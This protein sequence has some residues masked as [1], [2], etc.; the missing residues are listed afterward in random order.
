MNLYELFIG[1]RYLKSK[2]HQ[3][4]ISFN[5][6]LSVGIVFLGVFILVLV[7]SVMNGFQAQIK[8]KILDIDSHITIN[9]YDGINF[10]AGIDDYEKVA[11]KILANPDVVSAEP[12]FQEEGILSF[13]RKISGV[14]IRGI[15]SEEGIPENIGKFI[16]E[17]QMGMENPQR[18]FTGP[19]QV[20][21][22]KELSSL[23]QIYIDDTIE[24]IVAKQNQTDG[25]SGFAASAPRIEKLK[26]VGYFK[27]GY[28][29]F[30]TKML[31]T[32]LPTTQKIYGYEGKAWGIGVKV[33]DIYQVNRIAA[34]LQEMLGFDYQ[35]FTVEDRNENLFQALNIE[36]LV[37]TVILFLTIISAGFTIMGTLVMVVMEKRKAIGILKSLGAKPSSIMTIF[38][39]E[40]FLIGVIGTVAGLFTGIAAALNLEQIIISIENFI[41]YAGEWLYTAFN[42]GIWINK[43]IVPT[44]VY[45]ID[46]IPTEIKPGF[47]IFIAVFAVFLSTVASIFPAWHASRL[48]PVET[49][50][51]E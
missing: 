44:H 31:I 32:S 8:D 25:L 11:K 3:A 29:D 9:G 37:M 51:Y 15:G 33:R 4:F 40:G 5:T 14:M 47:V 27:T 16:D 35:T 28:Y 41:N 24:I 50:R 30:D 42:L 19:N 12:F 39:L 26:V 38:I 20:Y 21:I 6:L 36:R 45:Y 2:K 49:I 46:A 18:G 1:F 13:N 43:H 23:K 22:G 7:I 17:G 48:K 10:S 34:E